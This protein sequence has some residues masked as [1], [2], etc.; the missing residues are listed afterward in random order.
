LA[1]SHASEFRQLETFKRGRNGEQ[2]VAGWMMDR[3]WHVI[4]SYDYSGEDGNKAPKMAGKHSAYV[5][6]DLDVAQNGKR[7]WAEVK[8]KAEP[9]LHRKTGT[10][11]HGISLRHFREYKQ[12]ETITGCAVYLFVYEECSGDLLMKPLGEESQGRAYDGKVMGRGGMI[13]WPRAS[14]KLVARVQE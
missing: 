1:L 6:P 10:L 2:V 12:I 11:E 4:P 3:G 9:T 8:T 13:F 5:L 14:F 7:L